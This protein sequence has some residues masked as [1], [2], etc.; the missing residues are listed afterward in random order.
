[1]ITDGVKFG[2]RCSQICG[3]SVRDFAVASQRFQ[4]EAEGEKG[5][6]SG[7]FIAEVSLEEKLGS[8]GGDRRLGGVMRE[9]ESGQR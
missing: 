3:A 1:V 8:D 6:V 9:R 7:L 5:R 4:K 2:R